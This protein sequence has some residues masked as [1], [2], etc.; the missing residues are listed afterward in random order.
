MKNAFKNMGKGTPFFFKDVK[1]TGPSGAKV[2]VSDLSL[3]VK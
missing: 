3:K 2:K 1:V